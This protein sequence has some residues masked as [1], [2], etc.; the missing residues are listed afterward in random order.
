MKKVILKGP[1]FTNSGYGVHARQVFTALENR[2]DIDLYILPTNW[3]ETSWILNLSFNNNIIE[4]MLYYSKKKNPEVL[5][6]ESY[7][8]MLPNEWKKI[9]KKNIGITAGFET[10]IV[11][12]D[13]IKKCNEMC[14][15]IVPSEYSRL[16]F[17]K[18][19]SESNI[20]LNKKI[21]VINE[22]FYDDFLNDVN[23]CMLNDLPYKKNILLI[24]QIST[25]N[26]SAERKN[27]IKTL[28]CA[29][30]FTK[31]KKDIGVVLK[32]NIGK[33]SSIYKSKII[34]IVRQNIDK[35]L[36]KKITFLFGN[37]SILEL[38]G[39]YTSNKI[40]C[41]LSGTRAE[42]FGL[43]FLESAACGLPI[44]ATNHSAYLEFLQD[45]FLKVDFDFVMFNLDSNFV[46][47]NKNPKWAE[48]K[49]DSMKNMLKTFFKNE[50]YYRKQS[51]DLQNHIKRYYNK[52]NIIK[53]YNDFFDNV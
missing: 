45:K 43:T 19:S 51:F 17:E 53:K 39:L 48:F 40:S 8:V 3:G 37:F 16:A 38:K 49:Y 22:W 34:E 41:M 4:R 12:E 13:W 32:V 30:D 2:K 21:C 10:D 15:V 36:F 25:T 5:F 47:K 11:K 29:L 31:D 28:T 7:Q 52:N 44:I 42:G 26:I 1:V 20:K 9:A 46:D 23:S 18:T 6:D 50:E 14:N 27:F 33:N 35:N 24:S